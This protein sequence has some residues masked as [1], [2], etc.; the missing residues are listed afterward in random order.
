MENLTPLIILAAGLLL[1]GG[2]G[3][4][5][6]RSKRDDG[7][8]NLDGIDSELRSER[9]INNAERDLIADERRDI[10]EARESINV[11]RGIL[12]RDR[13]LLAELEKRAR[14]KTNE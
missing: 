6:R 1:G 2:L 14:G 8:R 7:S 3:F 4:L 9:E 11:E 13:E 12:D 10:A 5:G